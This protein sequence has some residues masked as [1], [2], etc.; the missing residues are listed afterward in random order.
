[1]GD[2]TPQARFDGKLMLKVMHFKWTIERQQ[3]QLE[4][5]KTV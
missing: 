2:K 3:N 5:N 1:M 4:E